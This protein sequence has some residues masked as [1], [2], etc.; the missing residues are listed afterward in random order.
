M[1]ENLAEALYLK[2]KFNVA[3]CECMTH[4]MEIRVLDPAAPNVCL[5][6][7]PVCPRLNVSSRFASE[8]SP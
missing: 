7:V 6:I 1:T 2:A 3:S 8:E 5:K 4:G